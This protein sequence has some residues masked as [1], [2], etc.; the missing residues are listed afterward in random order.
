MLFDAI[1]FLA[2][3]VC[4]SIIVLAYLANAALSDH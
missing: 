3:A 1:Y 4:L 2:G